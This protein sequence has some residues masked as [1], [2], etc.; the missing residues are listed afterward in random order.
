M[1]AFLEWL[2]VLRTGWCP[3]VCMMWACEYCQYWASRGHSAA[4]WS[5]L[6]EIW[7]KALSHKSI[8]RHPGSHSG[9]R[10]GK[11]LIKGIW[12]K[13]VLTFFTTDHV[14]TVVLP[15]I[16]HRNIQ[17]DLTHSYLCWLYP[18]NHY[19]VWWTY[20]CISIVWWPWNKQR[21]HVSSDHMYVST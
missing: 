1:T 4:K 5:E 3:G 14:K 21:E 16:G 9:R 15:T 17:S 2:P 7:H 13:K 19:I 12:R 6:A 18:D 10:P 8:S 11:R 20:V